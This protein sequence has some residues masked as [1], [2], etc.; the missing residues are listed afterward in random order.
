MHDAHIVLYFQTFKDILL[1]PP[2]SDGWVITPFPVFVDL[3][4]DN[5]LRYHEVRTIFLYWEYMHVGLLSLNFIKLIF[6]IKKDIRTSNPFSNSLF[7]KMPWSIPD[8]KTRQF[9]R[10]QGQF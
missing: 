10:I 9:I 1:H 6:K 5:S 4:R 7:N 8:K 2:S 3:S